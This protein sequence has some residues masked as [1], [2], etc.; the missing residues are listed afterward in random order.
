M[1]RVLTGNRVAWLAGGL[2]LGLAVSYFVPHEPA[3]ANTVDRD[4][5]FAMI[6]IPIG[7]S[8]AGINDPMDA[9]FILDFLTGQLKGAAL[10]RQIGKFRSFYFRDLSKDFEVDGDTDPHYCLSSGYAQVPNQAGVAM[11]SGMLYIGE[12]SSGM[13]IGYSFPWQETGTNGVVPLIPMDSFPFKKP[14]PKGK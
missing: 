3:Y 12:L 11:A 13:V 4:T 2:A 8:A 5:Q 10:N 14:A 1:Q 6:T 9:V 7:V